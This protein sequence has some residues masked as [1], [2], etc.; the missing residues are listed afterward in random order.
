MVRSAFRAVDD[1]LSQG[2]L[3]KL[4]RDF[5][6]CQPVVSQE[7]IYQFASNLAGEFMGTV[8]YNNEASLTMNIK[9]VCQTMTQGDDA[10]QNLVVLNKVCNISL[11]F[12][13]CM[14]DH[15]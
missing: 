1:I 3:T 9:Q 13:V 7:D 6:S 12:I 11:F 14:V 10:Y 5:L 15:R 4:S 2:N 8:Q